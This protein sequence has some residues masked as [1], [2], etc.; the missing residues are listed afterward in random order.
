[1]IWTN[2][3]DAQNNLPELIDAALHGEPVLIAVEENKSVKLVVLSSNPVRKPGS[4]KGLIWM[5]DDFDDPLPDFEEY[6]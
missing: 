2:V 1:M 3:K 6:S 4:A 5:A